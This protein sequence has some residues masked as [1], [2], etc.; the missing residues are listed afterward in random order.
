[1][2]LAQRLLVATALLALASTLSFGYGVREAW[3]RT[4]EQRFQAEFRAALD[5]LAR[6][7]R[8]EIEHLPALL[9]PIC[10]HDP[11]VDGALV[12]LRAGDL[13][14]RRLSLSL[15]V[16]ELAKAFALDEL[17]LITHKGEVLGAH[18]D[19]LVGRR[20][21]ALSA[22]IGERRE[23]SVLRREAPR[24]VEAACVRRDG[25]F[26]V[27]LVGARHVDPVL[28]RIGKSYGVELGFDQAPIDGTMQERIALGGLAGLRLTARRSRVPMEQALRE[29]DSKVLLIGGITVALALVLAALLSRGLS[30]PLV[31]LARQASEVMRG[32]PRPIEARGPREVEEAAAAFNR[33]IADLA[34]LRRSL[35]ASERIA[36]W[37]ETARHVAHEIKNPLAPIRAAIETLRRLRARNDPAFDDYFDEATRTA[38]DEVGRIN[39]IVT[40]FTRFARLPPPNPSELDL[41][42]V[43][44]SVLTLHASFGVDIAFEHQGNPVIR[45]DRDQLVQVLTNLIQNALDAV[46]GLA[47]PRVELELRPVA[48]ARIAITVRDNGPGVPESLRSRLFQPYATSKAH[49]TGLGLAI[50]QRLVVEHGGEIE[51]RDGVAGGAE[52]RIVL[53]VRGP[54]A[55]RPT[56]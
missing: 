54:S 52:F 32:E 50:A 51:H 35:A 20:D 4:E 23:R 22:R 47:E 53:P 49:G 2:T 1:V 42:E 33:A 10:K 40:E 29:L 13:E 6:E 28:S 3:R 5:P 9:E 43:V 15:R 18:A 8:R 55:D 11:L 25:T 19:G 26:W 48:G 24:A 21:P 12:G 30:R 14:S 31:E 56:T 17:L 36:A 34:Q 37:S 44:R 7:L 16:P 27:G 46:S 45:A 38:L 41:V 39:H